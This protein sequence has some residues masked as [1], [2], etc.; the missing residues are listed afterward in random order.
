MTEFDF[1]PGQKLLVTG[2][3]LGSLACT[4]AV[5]GFDAARSFARRLTHAR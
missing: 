1:T 3:W 2:M 4:L 5:V